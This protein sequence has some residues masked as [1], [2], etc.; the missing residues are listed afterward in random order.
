MHATRA[1]RR[2]RRPLG[3]AARAAA[4]A[5]RGLSPTATT[6]AKLASAL[7]AALSTT[8]ARA[9]SSAP[10]TPSRTSPAISAAPNA[11]ETFVS[12]SRCARALV[13]RRARSQGRYDG[14]RRWH[15]GRPGCAAAREP[16]DGICRACKR[17]RWR[18]RTAPRRAVLAVHRRQ[19]RDA[20]ARRPDHGRLRG[21]EGTASRPKRRLR[22]RRGLLA[23]A[24]RALHACAPGFRK[25]DRAT[26]RASRFPGFD[27][28][29]DGTALASRSAR[30]LVAAVKRLDGSVRAP[31]GGEHDLPRV[32]RACGIEGRTSPAIGPLCAACD[33]GW[34]LYN[35][36]SS[37]WPGADRR[38][39]AVLVVASR[40]ILVVGCLRGLQTRAPHEAVRSRPRRREEAPRRG[41]EQRRGDAK[42]QPARR[43]CASIWGRRSA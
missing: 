33:V 27:C 20:R 37:G 6:A 3:A 13:R 17:R 34:S 19:P 25:S 42:A 38:S 24:R 41:Q 12:R 31:T 35:G 5:W 21:Q 39:A 8:K 30:P 14:A 36:Q 4:C 23:R 9:A 11:S 18:R 28:S 26:R 16:V 7:P 22:V 10:S 43:A 32:D 2:P 29:G 1:R 40:V 15:V